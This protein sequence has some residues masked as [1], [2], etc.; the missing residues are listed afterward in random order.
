MTPS[1]YPATSRAW[2]GVVTPM[3]THTRSAPAAFVRE[4]SALARSS[5]LARSPVTPIVEA[6]YTKPRDA[7]AVRRRRSSREEGATRKTRS[8]F[9]ASEASIQADASSGMRSG[10][11]RP[12]PPA[13]ARSPAKASTP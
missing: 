5:R 4:T 12:A 1:A 7:A 8:R 2:S 11:M 10:V 13:S 9:R 3:P 6:A